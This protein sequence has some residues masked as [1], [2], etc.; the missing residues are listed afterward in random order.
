MTE[1][2]TVVRDQESH[3]SILYTPL[4]GLYM[5]TEFTDD[6]LMG[7]EGYRPVTSTSTTTVNGAGRRGNE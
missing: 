2:A 3:W 6:G 5:L 4:K 1:C 7:S